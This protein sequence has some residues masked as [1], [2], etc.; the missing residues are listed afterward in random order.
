MI[1]ME[2]WYSLYFFNETCLYPF[3]FC[4]YFQRQNQNFHFLIL[5][6]NKV[7]YFCK[8]Y[9]ANKETDMLKVTRVN[10]C[11]W[12]L[13]ECCKI[14]N[15][16]IV[17]LFIRQSYIHILLALKWAKKNV[18]SNKTVCVHRKQDIQY[19]TLWNDSYSYF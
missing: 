1:G 15:V 7:N 8:N 14:M 6:A 18:N 2:L 13:C 16:I 11:T 10:W 17:F 4:V 5:I 19:H 3:P 9:K 12:L